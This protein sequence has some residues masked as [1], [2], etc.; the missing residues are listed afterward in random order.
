MLK[1]QIQSK[2][3]V[4]FDIETTGFDPIKDQII[5]I[6]GIKINGKGE[7]I[8][9]FQKF[10]NLYKVDTIPAKIIEL[11]HITD[12]ML[13]K[14]GED[15][16][17]VMDEFY[18]FFRD[19]VLVAQNAKFD[20]S[21]I[22]YYY[23]KIKNVFLD[24]LVL[25]TIDL[26]KAIYPDKKTYKLS[27]LIEYFEIKYDSNAHHRADYD[28]KITSE[29]FIKGMTQLIIDKKILFE[30]Y[31]S[32]FKVEEATIN[33]KRYLFNLLKE[34]DISLGSKIYLSK[35]NAIRQISILANSKNI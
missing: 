34:T 2:T 6:G 8:D 23:L 28:A 11:T 17:F 3:Y 9:T 30:D 35:F 32:I 13:D 12:E 15:L 22:D 10:I 4:I 26:G 29:I 5:E 7:T 18:K 20:L 19:S 1:E 25:D 14:Q 24:N 33:Q 21:F 31:I 27:M 16:A